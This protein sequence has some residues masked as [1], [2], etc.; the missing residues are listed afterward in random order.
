MGD[1]A[2]ERNLGELI[3]YVL[4]CT[5]LNKRASV[6]RPTRTYL[7][8]IYTDWGYSRED[9]PGAMDDRD[10]WRERERESQGKLS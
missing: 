2:E 6:G 7:Q 9:P 4:L 10:E 8:Q 5:S 3:R 1:T